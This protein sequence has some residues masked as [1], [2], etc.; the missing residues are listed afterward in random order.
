[1]TG[2][3]ASQGIKDSVAGTVAGAACLFTGHPFDTLRVRLQTSTTKL[4]M[5]ECL[6]NTVEKEGASALYK[7]VTSPLFGMM[8][9]TAVLFVGYGQ[10]KKLLQKDP[11][12]PLE[13]WQ[14]SLCGAS[15]GFA[16]TFVLTPVELIKCRLQVQTTGPPKYK[17]TFDCFVKVLKEDGVTGLYRGIIPTLAREIP[18]NMAFFGVYEGLKRYFRT[19]TGQEDLPLR[20][21]I[22]SGGIGGIAYWS[23]FY[24]ADVAKSSIQVSDNGPTP[25]LLATLKKIYQKDG[26][27]G[28]YRGY[29][30]T[31]MR[32]FPAN[33]AMFT[34]YEMTMK[35]LD[36]VIP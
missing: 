3:A 24:P 20:Y 26:I 23:I 29:V 13:L 32:A 18:G 14:Y 16:A 34:V 28:L 8:F 31:V 9:E 19:K 33:A 6:K 36:K 15:A 25:S 11:N 12:K 35:A 2:S 21:L 10:M 30:L 5:I 22:L 4:G 27:R 17:G 1:M 7:G